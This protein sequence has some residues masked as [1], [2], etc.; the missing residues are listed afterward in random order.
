MLAA[1][2]SSRM[3]PH[4]KLL[5]PD[6]AGKPMVARVADNALASRARPVLVVTGHRAGEVAAALGGRPV[7]LVPA[8]DFADGLSASLRAGIA[9]VP[10]GCAAAL[11]CLG[12][13]PLV[14]GALID[15]LIAAWGE[16]GRPAAAMPVYAGQRGNPVLL[17][18][19]LGP[20]IARLSGDSGAGPLLRGRPDVFEW[21]V[22]D[23]AVAADIDTPSALARIAQAAWPSTTAPR[24]AT[25][26]R[27]SSRPRP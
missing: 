18:R 23:A 9:A 5:V 6:R 27:R 7:T 4:N 26:R 10:A 17:A 15:A 8:P 3:A 24:T 21:E 25:A 13:M 12:D 22:G 11:V 20:D 16:A 14:S 19:G 2:R 1:G